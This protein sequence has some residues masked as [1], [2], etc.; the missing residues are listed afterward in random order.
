MKWRD[1]RVKQKCTL[2]F[3]SRIEVQMS[4][5]PGLVVLKVPGTYTHTYAPTG[6]LMDLT[7]ISLFLDNVSRIISRGKALLSMDGNICIALQCQKLYR[8][9]ILATEKYFSE[10]RIYQYLKHAMNSL[11]YSINPYRITGEELLFLNSSYDM[12]MAY[13]LI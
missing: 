13:R 1:D 9:C 6:N 11:R 3:A 12:L 2:P 10:G 5:V 8:R 7:W 4:V